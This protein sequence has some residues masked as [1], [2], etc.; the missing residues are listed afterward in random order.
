MR[1]NLLILML[2]F[3]NFKFLDLFSRSCSSYILSKLLENEKPKR[4]CFEIF[5]PSV[6]KNTKNC[7]FSISKP[8]F[9]KAAIMNIFI[10]V[11]FV[12]LIMFYHRKGNAW[13]LKNRFKR[14]RRLIVPKK[15]KIRNA[16]KRPF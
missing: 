16:E 2:F 8:I 15:Q 6:K 14:Y 10:F 5:L 12:A 13:L 11:D 7:F 1:K 9:S 4:C 3:I